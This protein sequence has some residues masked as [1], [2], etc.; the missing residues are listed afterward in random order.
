M[1]LKIEIWSPDR[2]GIERHLEFIKDT[3]ERGGTRMSLTPDGRDDG[4]DGYR[5]EFTEVPCRTCSH[6]QLS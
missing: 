2:K 1:R 3:I 5:M 4:P 6:V